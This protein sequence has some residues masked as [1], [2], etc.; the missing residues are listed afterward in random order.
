VSFLSSGDGTGRIC[1]SICTFRYVLHTHNLLPALF[2]YN[3]QHEAKT[4]AVKMTFYRSV[5]GC[6]NKNQIRNTTTK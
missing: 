3:K 5:A 4:E 6:T 2:N 1:L